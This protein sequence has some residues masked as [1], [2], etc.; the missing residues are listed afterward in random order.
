MAPASQITLMFFG[1]LSIGYGR[2]GTTAPDLFFD[3]MQEVPCVL[4]GCRDHTWV[5]E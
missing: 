3:N 2:E 4:F 1:F 5:K